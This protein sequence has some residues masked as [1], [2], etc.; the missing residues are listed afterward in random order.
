MY[1]IWRSVS[2]HCCDLGQPDFSALKYNFRVTLPSNFSTTYSDRFAYQGFGEKL[3]SLQDGVYFSIANLNAGC[4]YI[5]DADLDHYYNFMKIQDG[6]SYWF[7]Q[8]LKWM[9]TKRLETK[10]YEDNPKDYFISRDPNNLPPIVIDYRQ[11]NLSLQTL[12]VFQ[13]LFKLLDKSVIDDTIYAYVNHFIKKSSMLLV[14]KDQH[15]KIKE[16]LEKH[17]FSEYD[18][19][20]E[21]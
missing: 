3:H 14:T 10:K 17:L 21:D 4:T 20:F 5:R 15:T 7:G 2:I 1:G 16:L 9:I 18:L 11:K 6:L 8:E 19:D 13:K 12:A